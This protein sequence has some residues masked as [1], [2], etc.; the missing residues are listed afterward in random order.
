MYLL[1]PGRHHLLTDFQFKYLNRLIK[2]NL[3]GEKDVYGL[4]LEA[5]TVEGIIFA[6]TSANHLGTKRNP[7]PF[8]IRAMV[9]QE[10]S[11]SL[12][13]PVYVYGIDDVGVIP[14]FSEYTVK[15]IRHS[16]ESVH[17]LTPDNTIVICSTSVKEMYLKRGFRVLPAELDPVTNTFTQPMPWDV[18]KL[19][20]QEGEWRKNKT[21]LDQM[22]PAAFHIW[23]LYSIGEKVQQI[24]KDP[25]IGADGDLTATRDYSVYVKQMDDIAAMK[26]RETA[27]YIQPGKIGDIGCAAGSWIKI[28]C[29][30]DRLHECDFYGI[31]VSRHL[32]D[33]CL[34]RKHNRE[35]A[36]PSVFFAQKNAV[37]SL[38]FEAGSMN[39]IHTSSLTHEIE[40]YGSRKDLIAFIH[41][42]YQ[43]LVP[44]GVWINRDVV[45]P[46][47][48]NETVL[49]WLNTNDGENDL[50]A[51]ENP[52]THE[53]AVWLGKLSTAALFKRFAQDF[54]HHEG[55]RLPHEWVTIDDNT[56]C[57]LSMQDACEFLFKKDYHDNWFS[58][59]HETFCFWNFNDWKSALEEA[60]FRL[61]NLSNA[62][63]NEWIVKNRLEGKVQLLRINENRTVEPMR[64]PDS[65]MLLLA[66]K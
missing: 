63:R 19:I 13:V 40:S 43:E 34:Q 32:Y 30:D 24:L 65:H 16:S 38:V 58:E 33:V 55:Y 1:I 53:L 7:V 35:F 29:E 11:N 25:I 14:D 10:F 50:P 57:K 21:V 37:T 49:L 46:E 8:Y 15:T 47:N 64:F 18:V 56:Y 2:C 6:V 22:H 61:D 62:Y 27:P 5:Q 60:G 4:P 59:M 31:E 3:E 26:Y 48:R 45:G 17:S 39:T 52:G 28:G 36:N 12:D 54:R 9:I 66:R 51:P 20:A 41:N 44:G 23:S 42:R